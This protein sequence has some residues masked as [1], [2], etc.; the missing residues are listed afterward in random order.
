MQGSGIGWKRPP[1]SVSCISPTFLAEERATLPDVAYRAEYCCEFTDAVDSAFRAEDIDACLSDWRSSRRDPPL[2]RHRFGQGSR[3]AAPSSSSTVTHPA[4]RVPLRGAETSCAAERLGLGQADGAQ[5]DQIA[6][7]LERTDAAENGWDSP[8]T[9][10]GSGHPGA[11]AGQRAFWRPSP[12]PDR[13]HHQ[14]RQPL[15]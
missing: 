12:Y 5:L 9:P 14:R 3:P 1:P 15:R 7:I 10:T 4:P 2:R 13:E 6:A 11:G 8:S